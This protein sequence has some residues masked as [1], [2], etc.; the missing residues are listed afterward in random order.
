MINLFHFCNNWL[1]K[2]ILLE[3]N[4]VLCGCSNDQQICQDC[5]HRL[6]SHDNH[7]HC[8]RCLIQ[9]APKELHCTNCH[10]NNFQFE[11]VISAFEYGFPLDKILHQLKYNHKIEYT[12]L[13]SQL[14]WSQ[15]AR[16]I[17]RLPEVII[18]VP[19]HP[20]K[21]KL[22]GFNQV[23]ELL[24]EFRQ[25]N[26]QVQLIQAQRTK[27]TQAQATLNRQ[28][29]LSNLNNAFSIQADLRGK[30]IAIVDDVVTSGTTVNELAKLC[31]QLGAAHVEIWCL[32][33][34]QH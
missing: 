2:V 9:L 28:Q 33:R 14:S 3:Q 7:Y 17:Q 26:P 23:H 5:Y 25:L 34:A 13:L 10:E 29:R 31:Q 4:C 6:I 32:M 11:R 27:E 22:R 12:T 30:S 8:P 1:E 20:K 18:P 16:Q 15:I 21:H 19:L 24:R